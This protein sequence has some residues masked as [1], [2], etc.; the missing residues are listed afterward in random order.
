MPGASFEVMI[1]IGPGGG[2]DIDRGVFQPFKPGLHF[3]CSVKMS[4]DL[5]VGR[6]QGVNKLFVAET[7]NIQLNWHHPG[8]FKK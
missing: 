5:H 4:M 1:P 3:Q 7:M 2:V 6:M 8:L